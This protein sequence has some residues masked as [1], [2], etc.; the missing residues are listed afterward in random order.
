MASIL[1][2]SRPSEKF[3]THSTSVDIRKKNSWQQSREARREVESREVQSGFR[4]PSVY[5]AGVI[6]SGA[7]LQAERDLARIAVGVG[8]QTVPAVARPFSAKCI[9]PRLPTSTHDL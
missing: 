7:V 9:T 3:G 6:P 5:A 8:N 4:G 1:D 2:L